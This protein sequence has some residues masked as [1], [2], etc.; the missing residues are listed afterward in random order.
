MS[1]KEEPRS[2]GSAL[3]DDKL[4]QRPPNANEDNS[5]HVSERKV[6]GTHHSNLGKVIWYHAYNDFFKLE[7]H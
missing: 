2:F 6:K 7:L 3:E 1:A 5:G 4:I